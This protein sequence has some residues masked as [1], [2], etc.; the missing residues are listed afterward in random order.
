MA[1]INLQP[2]EK[3]TFVARRHWFVFLT[4][5]IGLIFAVAIPLIALLFINAEEIS[6]LAGLSADQIH[7]LISFCF[8]AWAGVVFLIFSVIFTNYYLDL[9]IVTNKRIIDVEQLG[10]FARD[11]AI[12][13]LEN[14]EDIKIEVVGVLA[15]LL[16][17]G[18]LYVQTAATNREITIK[19]ISDPYRAKEAILKMTD[20]ISTSSHQAY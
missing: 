12:A 11:V 13:P 6:S 20:N 18:T 10:L 5:S 3:L 16:R 1:G 9:F 14:I 17:Y 2:G 15:T 4:E 7:A 19:G 8:A